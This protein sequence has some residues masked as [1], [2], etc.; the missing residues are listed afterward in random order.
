MKG[1]SPFSM[2][3][4][5]KNRN[6]TAKSCWQILEKKQ[7]QGATG[8]QWRTGSSKRYWTLKT[9]TLYWLILLS[10]S[11]IMGRLS[12]W[13]LTNWQKLSIH[14]GSVNFMIMPLVNCE[15]F[16][17]PKVNPELCVC[18][19]RRMPAKERRLSS[20]QSVLTHIGS[21]AA[22][23]THMLM[24]AKNKN[25]FLH[26][27]AIIRMNADGLLY[28]DVSVLTCPR[29]DGTQFFNVLVTILLFFDELQ[30]QLNHIRASNKISNTT[31]AAGYFDR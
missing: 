25:A 5:L 11:L 4:I 29:G 1:E 27:V 6:Q 28:L 19:G 10:L 21:I 23:A 9:K 24:K 18:L 16:L 31:S 8:L 30:T 15:I 3:W 26:L 22:K 17:T 20:T 7:C 12:Q 14:D 13:W 2:S